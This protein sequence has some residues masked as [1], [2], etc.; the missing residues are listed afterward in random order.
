MTLLLSFLATLGE[1]RTQ[2]NYFWRQIRSSETQVVSEFSLFIIWYFTFYI[3]NPFTWIVNAVFSYKR[4]ANSLIH[5]ATGLYSFHTCWILIDQLKFH[6]HW[7]YAGKDWNTRSTHKDTALLSYYKR[8]N[9]LQDNSEFLLCLGL[10]AYMWH[11][12]SSTKFLKNASLLEP[13]KLLQR[14]LRKFARQI[15]EFTFFVF[16]LLWFLVSSCL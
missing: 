10:M 8:P 11:G 9:Q 1:R 15:S 5:L 14:R 2:A 7:S 4:C 3:V 12:V 16:W 6:A 13:V